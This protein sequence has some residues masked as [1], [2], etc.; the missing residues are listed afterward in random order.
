MVTR[1]SRIRTKRV[2]D[3][4][5]PDDGTRVLVMR[6]WPRGVR[7]DRI[8]LW[9]RELGPVTPLL[10]GFLGGRVGWAE[11]RRCYLAGLA[12]PEAR[13]QL[14]ELRGLARQGPVTLL[15][16]CPEESRCHRSLLKG[17]LAKRLL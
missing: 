7:K 12:R 11:Y 17:H 5:G 10:R 8:D 1:T 13:A 16:R 15:C 14:T 6:L 4:T 2:Y 9:L 3:L